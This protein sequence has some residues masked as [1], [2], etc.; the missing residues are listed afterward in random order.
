MHMPI[1]TPTRR[2]LLVLALAA[3]LTACG[4][5]KPIEDDPG[6]LVGPT[7]ADEPLPD[8]VEPAP[9]AA[10]TVRQP[11]NVAL[12]HAIGQPAAE[13]T[14]AAAPAAQPSRR[15]ASDRSAL[16]ADGTAAAPTDTPTR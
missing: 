15:A 2:R 8:Q 11:G 6:T 10:D 7:A 5:S 13:A 12:G 14:A 1:P 4:G 16:N 9:V 3:L